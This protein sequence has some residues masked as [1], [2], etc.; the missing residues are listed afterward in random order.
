MDAVSLHHPGDAREKA[1]IGVHENLH[2]DDID[3]DPA[4]RFRVAA[5]R[6]NLAPDPQPAHQKLGYQHHCNHDDN[7]EGHSD[8][9]AGRALMAEEHDPLSP[10]VGQVVDL[11]PVR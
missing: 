4:C 7:R 9:V 1:E 3:A 8:D 10:P 11:G 5:K 6:V 2:A